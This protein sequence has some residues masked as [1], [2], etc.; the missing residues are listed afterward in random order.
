M[1]VIYDC[2]VMLEKYVTN[3]RPINLK[4]QTRTDKTVRLRRLN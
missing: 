4:L 3:F 2:L 1:K